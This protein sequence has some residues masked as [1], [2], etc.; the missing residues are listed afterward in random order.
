[1]NQ[2]VS[3]SSRTPFK[4]RSFSPYEFDELE[5]YWLPVK[6][7]GGLT[8]SCPWLSFFIINNDSQYELRICANQPLQGVLKMEDSDGALLTESIGMQTMENKCIA[9]ARKPAENSLKLWLDNVILYNAC[10]Q[11][12]TLKR[13]VEL[14]EGYEHDPIEGLYYQAKEWER[15]RFFARA[16]ERYAA[17]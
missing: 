8:Y 14:L 1:F 4:H 16:S 3:S 13:A 5:E 15:Q 2:S 7:T 11:K 12:Q 6:E 9:F 10:E 17:C